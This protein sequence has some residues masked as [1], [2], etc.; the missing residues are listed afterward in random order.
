MDVADFI[1]SDLSRRQFLGKSAQNAAGVAAGM[2]GLSGA[3]AQASPGE[4][5]RLG[6]LGIRNQGEKLATSLAGFADV[7]VT[8]VC[9]VDQ[10]VVPE[11]LK[12]IEAAQGFAPNTETDFRRVLDDESIDAVVIATPDHWHAVMAVMA[13][14]A[15]KDVYVEKP[16]SHNI[17]E[18]RAMIA[19]ADQYDRIVQSGLQQRSGSH[20]QSAIEYVAGGKLGRVNLAKAW[21]VHRRKPVGSKKNERIPQG[22]DYDLWLG[23]AAQADFNPNRFHYNWR[24]FWEFGGGELGNWGVHMLDIARWGL[25]VELPTRISASGGKYCFRDQE[26]PDTLVAQFEFPDNEANSK[27]I[28]WEHR[29]WSDHGIEGRSAAAAFYGENGTLIVDRGGWKVYD[30]KQPAT[31][32]SSEL[33]R[34]HQRNFI[35]C[36]KTRQTPVADLEIGH[37]SSTLC[38]LCNI[39]YKLGREVNFDPTNENFGTDAEANTLLLRDYREPWTIEV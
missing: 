37:I 15:G 22:V 20:F 26:T 16:V 10:N 36:I 23:P 9:D 12:S 32:N 39:A 6:V 29:Q 19:A 7:D 28:V 30:Q 24:W 17:A 35:D 33:A 27:T 3:V 31:S 8:T 2:V 25:N 18:G 34:A 13:C 4:R 38:H 14:Q 11:A 21:T 1:K 5:V